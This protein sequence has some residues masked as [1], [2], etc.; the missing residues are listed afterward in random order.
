MID[1][2]INNINNENNDNNNL[3]NN[4]NKNNNNNNYN[5]SNNNN[6][7]DP[8]ILHTVRSLRD[9]YSNNNN[10]I[11]SNNNNN[12]QDSNKINNHNKFSKLNINSSLKLKPG[13]SYS[14]LNP[15]LLLPKKSFV[16]R[17]ISRKIS[18]NSKEIRKDY[19]TNNSNN[20]NNYTNNDN[21]NNFNNVKYRESAINIIKNNKEIYSMFMYLYNKNSNNSINNWLNENLFNKK[22][23]EIKLE[24]NIKLKKNIEEFL[25]K[26]INRILSNKYL[27]T[28]FALKYK[29]IETINMKNLNKLNSIKN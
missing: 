1:K 15:I 6:N 27:D 2:N 8:R 29:E 5:N 3:K 14:S 21:K 11:L 23:F 9:S 17:S 28:K 12:N 7:F 22:V 4:D 26:E 19:N 13:S 24:I 10:N 20:N 18:I 25:L 16:N